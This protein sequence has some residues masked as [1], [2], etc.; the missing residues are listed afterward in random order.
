MSDLVNTVLLVEVFVTLGDHRL[1]L[2]H[3]D[4]RVLVGGLEQQLEPLLPGD[5]LRPARRRAP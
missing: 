3:L 2:V 4:D 5:L 1:H